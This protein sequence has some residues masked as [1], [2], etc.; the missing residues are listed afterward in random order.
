MFNLKPIVMKTFKLNH[1]L[2][3]LSLMMLFIACHSAK[4][5]NNS[6]ASI[7]EQDMKM[8]E[9]KIM[10]DSISTGSGAPLPTDATQV[11]IAEKI[12]KTADM[13][14]RV[15]E[16][17]KSRSEIETMVKSAS[18]FIAHENETRDSWRTANSMVIRVANKDFDQLVSKLVTV[19][20]DVNYKRIN[21]QDVT[22]QFVDI[23]ARLKTKK[24]IEQRYTELLAKASK[25]GDILEIEEKIRV[26]RE[27]IEA[28]EGQLKYLSNQVAYSTIN[29]SFYQTYE[30]EP[31]DKPGFFNRMGTAIGSGW[32]GFLTF[33]VGFTYA[34]PLWL[35]LSVGG[36]ILYRV[37]KKMI[38]KDKRIVK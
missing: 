20:K 4:E 28:K 1:L 8:V 14:M 23:Q 29:L 30:Y 32:Q 33:L 17:A 2:L 9:E 6:P 34:W 21:T 12:I 13:E 38:N 18:A 5:D 3:T 36:W 31:A 35:I 25:I 11:K 7:M 27:E 26:I 19:A 16:Y 24:E 10:M 37:I 15:E 22:D